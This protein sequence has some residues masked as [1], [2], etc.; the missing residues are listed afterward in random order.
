[1][2]IINLK[3]ILNNSAIMELKLNELVIT[4]IDINVLRE[5]A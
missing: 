5:G 3:P 1:M 4:I 2:W